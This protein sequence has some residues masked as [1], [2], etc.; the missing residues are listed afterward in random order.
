MF[1]YKSFSLLLYQIIIKQY[2]KE[3]LEHAV[4]DVLYSKSKNGSSIDSDIAKIIS[5]F[6]QSNF[7]GFF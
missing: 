4:T 7:Q 6:H 2:F 5:P 1:A 3:E